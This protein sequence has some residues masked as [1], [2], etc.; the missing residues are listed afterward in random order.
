MGRIDEPTLRL[1]LTPMS[2]PNRDRLEAALAGLGL[3]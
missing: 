1:P 2:K 3:E